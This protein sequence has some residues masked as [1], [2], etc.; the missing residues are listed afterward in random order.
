MGFDPLLQFVHGDDAVAALE[1]AVRRPVDGPVNV[2][3]PGSVSLSRLLRLARR[4]PVPVPGPLFGSTLG[5]IARLGFPR[6]PP[7][8]V[9][10]LRNGV[11]ID[12]TRLIE[13]V[14]FTPRTT[15]ETVREFVDQLDG[16]SPR[17]EHDNLETVAV[18]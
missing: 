11:T 17:G 7:D 10:W 18:A 13:E 2:A 5:A 9:P 12:V 4:I 16:R 1:A 6:L 3:G 15:L 14:G 8:A